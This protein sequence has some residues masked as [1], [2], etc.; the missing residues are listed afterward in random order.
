MAAEFVH[1]HLHTQ[2]SLLDG[3]TRIGDLMARTG[4][5]GMPAVALT[6]HGNMFGA[7]KFYQAAKRAGIKPIIG[8]EVYVAPGS[9]HDRT[10]GRG[11]NRAFHMVLLATS[12]TGYRNLCEL[13]TAGYTEGMYY[14]P[15][16]DRELLETRAEGLICTS[17]CLRGEVNSHLLS[18]NRS[19]AKE[20]AAWYKELFPGR[21]YLEL[22]DHGLEEDLKVVPEAISLAREMELPLIASNDV[23]YL[24]RGDHT[25]Q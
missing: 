2:Y 21:F 12:E 23:H 15:R 16:I 22:Q 8:C 20:A 25:Y 24:N 4:E 11:A 5:L 9:R 7:V 13:V 1:L 3:T 6:D 17:A 14:F 19:A 18:G 10:E